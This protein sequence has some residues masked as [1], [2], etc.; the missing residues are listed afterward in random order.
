M[1][2]IMFMLYTVASAM[3]TSGVSAQSI[4][5]VLVDSA[6]LIIPQ[7]SIRIYVHY[8]GV[9]DTSV[10]RINYG[11]NVNDTNT[12]SFTVPPSADDTISVVIDNLLPNTTYEYK[13]MFFFPVIAQSP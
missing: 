7:S 11:I 13:A 10:F 12:A 1:K 4:D 2:K 8:Y 3:V 9:T 6:E 5:S